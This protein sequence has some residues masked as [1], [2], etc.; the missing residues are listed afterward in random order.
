MIERETDD[1]YADSRQM[2]IQKTDRDTTDSQ[3]TKK[4]TPGNQWTYRRRKTRKMQTANRQP[5]PQTAGKQE[6]YKQQ[7]DSRDCRQQENRKQTNRQ[8]T[9]SRDCRQQTGR[10]NTHITPT[11][12]NQRL[13]KQKKNCSKIEE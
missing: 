1:W 7:I 11:D 9:D 8:Q 6:T 2:K 4:H 13:D 3:T 12:C 10:K 5:R